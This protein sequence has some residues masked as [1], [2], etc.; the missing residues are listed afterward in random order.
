MRLIDT[1]ELKHQKRRRLRKLCLESEFALLQILS[2]LLYLVQFVKC[3][4]IL[5]EL[6]FNTLYQ[7]SGKEKESR[8]LVFMSSKKRQ[9]MYFHVLVVL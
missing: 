7:S 2:R 1:R 9:I 5:L 3:W 6:N 8:F 4:R